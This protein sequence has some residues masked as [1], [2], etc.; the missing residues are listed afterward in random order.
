MNNLKIMVIGSGLMGSGIAQVCIVAGF[1]VLLMDI[2]KDNVQKGKKNIEY[3]LNRKVEKQEMTKDEYNQ[4]IALL[5]ISDKYDEGKDADLIIE[6][7]S[8]NIELKKKLFKEIEWICKKDAILATNTS[9]IS[10]TEISSVVESCDRVIGVHFFSPVPVMELVEIIC[11][12]NTSR[13]AYET[14]LGFVDKLG[15]TAVKAPDTPGFLVNRLLVPMLNEAVILLEE[16][17]EAM[18]ID[19]AMKLGTNMPM[20]PLELCDLVGLDV[21]LGAMEQ[22]YRKTKD[23]KYRPSILMQ[24][25]VHAGR[26]GR[27]TKKGFYDY[28]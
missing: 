22:I 28:E 27:K 3:R 18:D 11:G 25:M 16:G 6:A 8:E 7:V 12:I 14:V 13:E 10:I 20:G 15:K 19:T 5:T 26:L 4:A 24:N 23:S 17:N 2:S 21:A 9:T 1:K